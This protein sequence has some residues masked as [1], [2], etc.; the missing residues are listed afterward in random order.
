MMSKV[1]LDLCYLSATEALERFRARTL[2][3]VELCAA[4]IARCA[5]VNPKINA[6]TDSFFD[7]ASSQARAAEGRYRNAKSGRARPLEG[8]TVTIK[9]FHSVK[10]RQTTYGTKVYAGFKPDSTAPTVDR[11]LKAGA[12]LFAR[13]TTSEFAHSGITNTP[14]W[15]VT[16]NPWNTTCT[17]GGSSGGA[18]AV[19]AAGMSTLADGTDGGGSCRIP[20]AFCGVIGYKPPFGRNPLDREHPLENLLHYGPITRTVGDAAL[21][22]NVMSGIHPVDQCSLREKVVLPDKFESIRGMKIAFSPNLDYQEIAPDVA[23]NTLEVVRAL[24]R[25]GAKVDEVSLGWDFSVLDAW[26]VRW[27][28][29]FA[30]IGGPLLPRWRYDMLPFCVQLIENGLRHSAT[31]FYHINVTRGE[32]YRSLSAV[33]ERYD[34][35]LCPTLGV[36]SLSATHDDGGRDLTINGRSVPNYLGWSLTYPFN[37]MAWCPVMS[38]PS[39]FGDGGM[40]TAVQ[41]VGRTFDDPTVFRIASAL[42]RL[43]PW[44][45]TRPNL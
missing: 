31:R 6:L 15:G 32:M 23:R 13:S 30:D 25:A 14:L 28:G 9:D 41:V 22:Q 34:A 44:G 27:E 36:S 39:G 16:R 37:L 19:M 20:A 5:A 11:L 40:P 18:G 12:I 42:E 2:S 43:R 17:P 26:M 4:L 10:G 24:K 1:D 35:M 33:L 7:E 21:M 3:P 8:L 45:G 38:V 29:I